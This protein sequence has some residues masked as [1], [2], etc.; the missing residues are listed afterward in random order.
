[1]ISLRVCLCAETPRS[2]RSRC[3]HRTDGRIGTGSIR[4]NRLEKPGIDDPELPIVQPWRRRAAASGQA[5]APSALS[6][7]CRRRSRPK[8]GAVVASSR[9]PS[10]AGI[11]A[12]HRDY[13]GLRPFHRRR[14]PI[15]AT[16]SRGGSCARAKAKPITS[17]R[18]RGRCIQPRAG[19]FCT[20]LEGTGGKP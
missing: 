18:R 17:R 4:T 2:G 10:I 12:P 6:P 13:V 14:P 1:V 19:V 9:S 8:A 11:A 3:V 7:L 16:R 20:L 5:V 15:R